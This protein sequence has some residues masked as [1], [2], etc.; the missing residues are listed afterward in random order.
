MLLSCRGEYHIYDWGKFL[1]FGFVGAIHELPVQKAVELSTQKAVEL[2]MQKAIELSTQKTAELSEQKDVESS[3][4][5]II[6]VDAE[7]N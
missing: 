1:Y 6:D 7:N 5:K 4:R 2:S 3:E